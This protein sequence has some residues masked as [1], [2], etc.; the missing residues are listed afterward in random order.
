MASDATTG[1]VFGFVAGLVADLLFDLPVGVSAL[2]YTAVGFAVGT[3]RVYV[4]SHHPLVHLVLAGAASLAS[5][6]CCGL[7]LRVFDLSSWAAV[8]RAG[9]LVALLQPAADPV[10]LPGGVGADRARPRPTGPALVGSRPCTRRPPRSAPPHGAVGPGRGAVRRPVLA[11]VVPPGAGRRALRRPGRGQPGPPGRGRGPTGPDPGRP[12][13][14]GG[15]QP[16]RLG[17]HGQA[18]GARRPPPRGPRPPGPPA[19]HHP[20]QAGGA[21]R[22]LRRLAPARHPG[23]RGRPHPP[24]LPPDRARR[25][26]PRGRPRGA[27]PARVPGR[28]GRRPR[29]RLRRRDLARRAQ[30]AALPRL[31]GRRHR[32]QGRGRADLRQVAARPRRRPGPRGQRGRRG[33]PGP[34]RPPAGPRPRPPAHPRPQPPGEC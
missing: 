31:R 23:R 4:T 6:W 15:P 8:A 17:G 16:G 28:G 22:R 26:L 33:G 29:A 21:D 18:V 12:R 14:G 1:A 11:P 32:R 7:L 9:P 20:G 30:A 25:P 27:G 19:R 3:V 34:R 13:A 5:V 24:A 10:R 2:V